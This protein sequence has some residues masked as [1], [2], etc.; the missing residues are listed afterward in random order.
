M[1]KTRAIVVWGQ[2]QVNNSQ[3]THTNLTGLVVCYLNVELFFFSL[4]R[5]YTILFTHHQNYVHVSGAVKQ[6]T[7]ASEFRI[8]EKFDSFILLA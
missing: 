6:S 7:F 1:M 3:K 5:V 2:A 4:S 8:H